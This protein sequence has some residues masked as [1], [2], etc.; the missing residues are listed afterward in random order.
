MTSITGILQIANLTLED[1]GEYVCQAF[2][3]LDQPL[4]RILENTVR[5]TVNTG[6]YGYDSFAMYLLN[7]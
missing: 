3:R 4:E 6:T 1:T 2:P 5:L 7:V